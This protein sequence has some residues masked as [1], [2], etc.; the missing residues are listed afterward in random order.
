MKK[1]D[2][3]IP[4]YN[5][6]DFLERIL[7]Y[8]SIYDKDFNFIVADSSNTKNKSHNKKIISHF[9]K[10]SILYLDKFPSNLSQHD[11]F[12]KMVKYAKSKYICF[13]ADDDFIV[14]NGIKEAVNFLEKN[15]DYSAAHGTYISF[16][17]H[18]T[19]F[20][21]N[22]FWW[23][24]LYSPYSISSSNPIDRVVS[25]L[26]NYN[27]VIWAVRRTSAVKKCYEEFS[28][29]KIDPYLLPV[30]G[31]LLPDVLTVIYGKI[32]HINN[33]YAARQSFSQVLSSYPSLIDAKEVGIYKREYT[34]FKRCLV[35]NLGMQDQASRN[36][37]ENIINSAI[38]LYIKYSYQEHIM[39][40]INYILNRLPKF[41]SNNIKL[42]HAMYLFSKN[43]TD[44]KDLIGN[45]SSKYFNDFEIIRKIVLKHMTK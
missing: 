34:K 43:K 6:P 30:F 12:A 26:T 9:P 27:M 36:K 31:E 25:H 1:I 29:T 39:G 10:L 7:D 3:I 41:I 22:K 20:G 44:K 23:R 18:K 42:L 16:Y 8:Y 33:F 19:P 2:L 40:K 45:P 13:C 17:M 28:K 35:N 11:K 21:L 5:R 37:T 15:P 24:F 4:T 38:D 32:K 14:P